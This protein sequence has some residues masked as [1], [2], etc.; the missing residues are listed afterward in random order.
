M[1]YQVDYRENDDDSRKSAFC[2][3]DSKRE[4]LAAFLYP[5]LPGEITV[6]KITTL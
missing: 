2:N 6:T 5:F 1:I 4:A 3:G